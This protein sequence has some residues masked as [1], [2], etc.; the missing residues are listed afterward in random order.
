[1]G[2][3]KWIFGGLGFVMGGPIGA[4]IGAIIGSFLES[5]AKYEAAGFGGANP[6]TD[7]R[8]RA[9]A[10]QDDIKVSLLVL[11][12]CVMKADGHLKKSELDLVKRF[13]VNNYG[14]EGALA[15]LKMLKE[16]LEKDLDHEA[17]AKQIAR[18]VNYST[19]RAL[20]QFLLDLAYADGEFAPSEEQMIR[21]IASALGI[22][23]QDVCSLFAM[24]E[25]PTN[26]NWAYE[27]LE[28]EPTASDDEVKKAYRRVAMKY[29][30]DK[31]AS[32]GEE[33]RAKATEKFQK[34]QEAYETIKKNR[35]I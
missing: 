12:A 8:T 10:T 16:L 1:M 3:A 13:L 33:I 17:M 26:P 7:A 4:V 11:I 24:Y 34:I 18:Y 32:A 25:Q 28:I 9:R 29:H 14:E 23:G 2:K 30:P 19:R 31:V 6:S 22:L 35:G 21:S 27:V 15:A 20:L 5:G